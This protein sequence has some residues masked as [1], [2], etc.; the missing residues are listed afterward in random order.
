MLI[1]ERFILKPGALGG[2]PRVQP[3]AE[4]HKPARDY[5]ELVAPAMLR[6][7]LRSRL[8][9]LQSPHY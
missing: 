3:Q 1:D 8:Y 5:L 4:A 6:Q 2:T 9:G 7:R